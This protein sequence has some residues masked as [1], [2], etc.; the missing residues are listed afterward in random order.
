MR[1][2]IRDCNWEHFPTD[3]PGDLLPSY[4]SLFPLSYTHCPRGLG[5]KEEMLPSRDTALILQLKAETSPCHLELVMCLWMSLCVSFQP[6]LPSPTNTLAR[7]TGQPHPASCTCTP[8]LQGAEP[9]WAVGLEERSWLLRSGD[10]G[11][12]Y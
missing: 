3:K 12:T 6:G 8:H 2:G 4:C 9:A 1:P 11:Q 7:K 10:L 5:A